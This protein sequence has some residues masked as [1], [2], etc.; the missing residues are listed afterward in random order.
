DGK[1]EVMVVGGGLAGLSAATFLARQGK[2]VQLL[3]RSPALGGRAQSKQ[4]EGFY[5][6]IGP[7]AL[8][9]GGRGI[10]ILRELGVEARGAIPPLSGG[11]A[12]KDGVKHALPTGSLSLLVTGLFGLTAK[13]ETA[14]LLGSL[15]KVDAGA[16]M[17]VTVR[18][19]VERE[20]AHPD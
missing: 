5:L 6:N 1:P 20:I 15:G 19:W 9:R 2:R 16:L 12:I 10:E 17:G 13:L 18:D 11:F 3:E 14:R 4:H 8:Y 7:H